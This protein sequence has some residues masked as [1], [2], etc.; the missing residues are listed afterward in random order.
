MPHVRSRYLLRV[1]KS[2]HSRALSSIYFA[3]FPP[4]LFI[5]FFP[6]SW[7]FNCLGASFSIKPPLFLSHFLVNLSHSFLSFRFLMVVYSVVRSDCPSISFFF[8]HLSSLLEVVGRQCSKA[9]L[10]A[11]IDCSFKF[12]LR[13][14]FSFGSSFCVVCST[15]DN[16]WRGWG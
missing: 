12:V 15:F 4:F 10:F 14:L 2:R 13:F 8:A 11:G 16:V 3:F 6:S 1:S 9:G 5:P 7:R